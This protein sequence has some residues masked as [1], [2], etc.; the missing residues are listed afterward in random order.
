MKDVERTALRSFAHPPRVWKRYLDDTFCIIGEN[1]IEK[2]YQHLNAIES[3]IEF[4]IKRERDEQI[5]FLDVLVER[6][7]NGTVSTSVYK[8]KTHTVKYLDFSSHHP[9]VHKAAVV[10]TL[11]SSANTICSSSHDRSCEVGRVTAA[12]RTNGDPSAFILGC[13]NPQRQM[14]EK[15]QREP[16]TTA[17]LPYITGVSEAIQRILRHVGISSASKPLYT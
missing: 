13:S 7:N 4:T 17:V 6:E 15:S 11:F 2:F 16:E 1:H 12:L 5:S 14:A 10:T 3:C 9:A 8:K